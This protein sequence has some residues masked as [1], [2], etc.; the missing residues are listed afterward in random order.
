MANPYPRKEAPVYKEIL[1]WLLIATTLALAN[2][3]ILNP[4]G[5]DGTGIQIRG[6][7][8]H[9][10]FSY[11][12]FTHI[13][14]LVA[15]YRATLYRR[16]AEARIFLQNAAG[17]L[18]A[19]VGFG[20]GMFNLQWFGGFVFLWL[21]PGHHFQFSVIETLDYWL[22]VF[23]AITFIGIFA[24]S[25]YTMRLNLKESYRIHLERERLR[26][27]L[28]TAR[29]MQMELMP[30]QAPSMTGLDVAG[31]CDPAREVGGDFYDYF[32]PDETPD[33]LAIAVADVSGK[34]MKAAMTAVMTSGMLHAAVAGGQ[35]PDRLLRLINPPLYQKSDRRMFTTMLFGVI[36][37]RN[38]N[39]EFVNAGQM[40]PMLLR[41][42]EVVTLA[43]DGPRLPL[44]LTNEVPYSSTTATLRSGDRIL[45]Y[46]D[47]VNESMNPDREL[48]GTERLEEAFATTTNIPGS[49]EALAHIRSRID[50]FTDGN[51]PHDDI[52]MVM[53]T[54]G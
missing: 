31:V 22:I 7:I 35:A 34:G 38:R 53:V 14:I 9:L 8:L 27:E 16:L 3:L 39:F 52:T 37:T 41:D 12:V 25:Y 46:T 36:D 5:I 23:V 45:L 33:R 4:G 18:F 30:S 15:V 40:P 20:A 50:R 19:F 6:L 29:V 54:V 24:I 1:I 2:W 10:L 43:A 13:L 32:R 17:L 44:G 28:E 11:F 49:S 21:F 48:F 47:G 42:G 26:G 51:E